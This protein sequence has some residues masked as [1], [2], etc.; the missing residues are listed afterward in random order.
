VAGPLLLGLALGAFTMVCSAYEL[1]TP[2]WNDPVL[3]LIGLVLHTY[4]TM[5][6]SEELALAERSSRGHSMRSGDASAAR[7]WSY[8]RLYVVV[9]VGG[10]IILRAMSLPGICS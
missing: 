4:L 8:L 10:L 9:C 5:W 7:A 3:I 6:E 1:R 2:V